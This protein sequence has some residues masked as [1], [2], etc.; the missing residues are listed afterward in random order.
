[1]FSQS[2]HVGKKLTVSTAGVMPGSTRDEPA[3]KNTG[4]LSTSLPVKRRIT[5]AWA[6]QNVAEPD[7]YSGWSAVPR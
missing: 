3:A 1:M 7:G 4:M 6:A 2:V 5:S